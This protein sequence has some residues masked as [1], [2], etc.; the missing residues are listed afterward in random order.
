[1]RR[2]RLADL[3][4]LV[5]V[6]LGAT[7]IAG[8]APASVTDTASSSAAPGPA[9]AAARSSPPRNT[10]AARPWRS[11]ASLPVAGPTSAAAV[12]ASPSPAATGGPVVAPAPPAWTRSTTPPGATPS[13]TTVTPVSPVSTSDAAAVP[14]AAANGTP[15]PTPPP[16]VAPVSACPVFP[17]S[18][19]WN[20]R[21]DGLP[22]AANSAAMVAAIGLDRALHP[23]FSNAGGYGIPYNVVG[24]GTPRS[25]VVFE[26]DGE[27]DHV[28]YPIPPNPAIEG[29]SDRH[30]LLVGTHECRLYELFAAS[31]TG[32]SWQAGSGATWDL[33]SNALRPESWTSAD[34]AGLPIFAGLARH[35]EA[36]AGEIRHAL[37]FTAPRTCDGYI[38][39]ARH[40]AGS[41][42]C[43]TY[44]PMGLRVRLRADLDLTPF[45]PQAR[46][47][48]VALQRYGAI[49]ADN[50]SAW[51]VT[52]APSAGWD[53]DDLHGLGAITGADFEV[54]DTTGFVN[55]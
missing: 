8:A 52:G 10:Q 50:G 51:Y 41:G 36:A 22:V 19:V 14:D 1:M 29:G 3:L 37:R 12:I 35:E 53:D 7:D 32:G 26:Y 9:S 27:S 38:Y 31:F 11:A 18:N 21:V 5:I 13:A 2:M 45:G 17:A 24:A 23:D 54:V 48:L 46:A 33:L 47:V 34:A 20:R 49:L 25:N 6:V 15:V 4:A 40:E 43:A 28:G 42:S 55:G 30:L 39:P 16:T 44:P